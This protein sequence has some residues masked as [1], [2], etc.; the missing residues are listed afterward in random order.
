MHRFRLAAHPSGR[1]REGRG[2]RRVAGHG[3]AGSGRGRGQARGGAALERC[4]RHKMRGALK[5]A[6]TLRRRQGYRGGEE[7]R[8][9]GAADDDKRKNW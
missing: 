9:A 5:A 1:G 4:G 3:R 8:Q 6:A 2:R 7:V